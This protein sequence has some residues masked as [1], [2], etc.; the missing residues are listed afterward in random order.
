M[1]LTSPAF[2]DGGKIPARYACD[3][4]NI[5]PPLYIEDVPPGARSLALIVD[6]PDAPSGVWT[7]WTVWNIDPQTKEIPEGGVPENALQ[8]ETSSGSTGYEG[9]CPPSGVHHYSFR[10]YALDCLADISDMNVGAN[11]PAGAPVLE[12]ERFIN[13]HF[14]ESAELIGTYGKSD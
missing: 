2:Q 13:D 7:H 5:N 12:V 14:L 3:G 1:K 4:E 6:D 9:P 11:L 10:I 8:G